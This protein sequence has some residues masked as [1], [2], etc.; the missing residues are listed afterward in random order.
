MRVFRQQL[1]YNFVVSQE[2]MPL[3]RMRADA[4][5]MQCGLAFKISRVARLARAFSSS[6]FILRARQRAF[7]RSV[8]HLFYKAP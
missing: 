7:L 4:R 6:S 3:P 2:P 1:V 5:L 8:S